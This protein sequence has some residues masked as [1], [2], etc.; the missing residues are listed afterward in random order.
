MDDPVYA[1]KYAEGAGRWDLLG[2]TKQALD[3]RHTSGLNGMYL[4]G[5]AQ[6]RPESGK[7]LGGG[8]LASAGHQPLLGETRQCGVHVVAPEHQVV[9]DRETAK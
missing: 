9:A 8:E 2:K 4:S 1:E 7:T 6:V 5:G 3:A